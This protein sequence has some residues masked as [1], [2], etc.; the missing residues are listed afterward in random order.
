MIV[1]LG[2][3]AAQTLLRTNDPISRLRGKVFQLRRRA[4]HS[5]PSTRPT[6]C[7]APNASAR[8]G[9]T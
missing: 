2:T 8:S 9:R 1:A 5:R 6:C 7:A 3:F 4:A